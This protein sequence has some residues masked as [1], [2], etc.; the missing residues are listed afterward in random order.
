MM[1]VSVISH[2]LLFVIDIGQCMSYDVIISVYHKIASVDVFVVSASATLV[3]LVIRYDQVSMSLFLY[4]TMSS[5]VPPIWCQLLW[6]PVYLTLNTS[7]L[8][9]SQ[10]T[11]NHWPQP[12]LQNYAILFLS[13]NY[14]VPQYELKVKGK[15]NHAPQ[16]N[17][18]GC[19]SPSSRPWARR[20]RTTNAS[21]AWTVRRQTYGYL[22][23]CKALPPIG[24]Y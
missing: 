2:S 16:E 10:E 8:P 14:A 22:P 7:G 17:V 4:I 12:G 24:W 13:E 11:A 21:D 20:W 23:N 6:P 18:G 1:L 3:C 15:V 9:G 19:S 5:F